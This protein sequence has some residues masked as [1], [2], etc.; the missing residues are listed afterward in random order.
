M[1]WGHLLNV[2][3]SILFSTRHQEGTLLPIN[4]NDNTPAFLSPKWKFSRK[5]ESF[6]RPKISSPNRN[7]LHTESLRR[8]DFNRNI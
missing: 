7:I 6:L 1:N 5:D 8:V 4:D 3:S 2:I